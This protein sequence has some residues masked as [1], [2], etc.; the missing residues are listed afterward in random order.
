MQDIAVPKPKGW[1][2]I[3]LPDHSYTVMNDSIAKANKLP[4]SFEYPVMVNYHL[5]RTIIPNPDGS[6]LISLPI[7]QKYT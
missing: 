3:D 4:L 5:N 6:I 2:R 1:F 7:R